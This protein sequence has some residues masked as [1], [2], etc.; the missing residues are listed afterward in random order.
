MEWNLAFCTKRLKYL[1][2]RYDE[3][4]Y[5]LTD[6]KIKN[7]KPASLPQQVLWLPHLC[8]LRMKLFRKAHTK[9][10]H[11]KHG[12]YIFPTSVFPSMIHAQLTNTD[13]NNIKCLF[14]GSYS[15]PGTLLNDLYTWTHISPRGI[16]YFY[17]IEKLN[18]SPKV[19]SVT[20]S[21]LAATSHMW[22][23]K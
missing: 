19:G 9:N 1:L 17:F 12:N 4:D 15:M 16:Y 5:L 6:K 10:K 11:L 14:L 23:F 20:L 18:N 13:H 3:T 7:T 2:Y 22:L 21:N 8:S